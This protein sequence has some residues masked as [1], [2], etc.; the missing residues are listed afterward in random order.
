MAYS[1]RSADFPAQ[2]SL[3]FFSSAEERGLS[4]LAGHASPEE[5]VALEKHINRPGSLK[6]FIEFLS[7]I[8]V[9]NFD[10]LIFC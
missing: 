9:L 8:R 6:D 7:I 10:P 2:S 4:L 3:L 5:M 1:Y